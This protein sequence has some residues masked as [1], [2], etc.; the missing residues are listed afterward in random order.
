MIPNDTVPNELFQIIPIT[1]SI[2]MINSD[3]KCAGH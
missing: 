3:F 2:C 1:F